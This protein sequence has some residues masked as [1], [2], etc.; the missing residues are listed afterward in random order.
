[1]DPERIPSLDRCRL[2]FGVPLDLQGFRRDLENPGKDFVRNCGPVWPQYRWSVVDPA[3]KLIAAARA[4]GAAVVVD[5]TLADLAV[6]FRGPTDLLIL[7]AH[8][9]PGR[10]ELADA[11]HDIADIIA[12]VPEG[13]DGAVDLCVCQSEDLAIGL[14]HH[15]PNSVVRFADVDAVPRLWFGYL[16]ALLARLQ[17]RDATYMQAATEVLL[18]FMND[19]RKTA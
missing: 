3:A 10:I 1:M 7:V 15:R 4:A 16:R 11:I 14:R 9:L 18:L 6:A 13:F 2:L 8:W 12:A 5:A 17:A 19:R